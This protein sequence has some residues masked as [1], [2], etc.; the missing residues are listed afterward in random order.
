MIA[1]RIPL[2]G[3][4]SPVA[5]PTAVD[6]PTQNGME[7]PQ[8]GT[9]LV[10]PS[11]SSPTPTAASTPGS[12]DVFL[13]HNSADKPAVEQL[14]RRLLAVGIQ[15][16]LDS[17]N[18]IPSDPWQEGLEEALDTCVMCDVFLGPLGVGPWNNGETL[19]ALDAVVAQT[20]GLDRAQYAHVLST[21]SHK[22]DPHAPALCLARFDELTAIG[23]DPFTKRWDLYWERAAQGVASGAGD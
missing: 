20:C 18:L 3:I 6:V 13:S 10:S 15:P 11:A 22:S 4:S 1:V 7:C 9:R 12:C 14:A 19:A 21:F 23:L 17:W 8:G 16:W 5:T 2:H